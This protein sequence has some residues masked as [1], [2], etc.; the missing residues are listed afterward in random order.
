MPTITPSL[1]FDTDGEEA[2]E[3]YVSVFPNSQ[4]HHATPAGQGARRRRCCK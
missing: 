3:F 1:W 2:A 4:I